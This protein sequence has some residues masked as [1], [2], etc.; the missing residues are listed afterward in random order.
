MQQSMDPG[1]RK[2]DNEARHE[3]HN[4]KGSSLE[5]I[6]RKNTIHLPDQA[7]IS[8]SHYHLKNNNKKHHHH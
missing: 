5:Y 7:T 1:K 6:L 8:M 3:A 4:N 2:K